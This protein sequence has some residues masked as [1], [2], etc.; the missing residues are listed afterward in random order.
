[1][2]IRSK[3][4]S[5]SRSAKMSAMCRAWFKQVFSFCASEVAFAR[6]SAY[7]AQTVHFAW[8]PTRWKMRIFFPPLELALEG[9]LGGAVLHATCVL[10]HVDLVER[11]HRA[12]RQHLRALC[13]LCQRQTARGHRVMRKDFSRWQECSVASLLL[14][15]ILRR[16]P[17]HKVLHLCEV[18]RPTLAGTRTSIAIPPSTLSQRSP[19]L[20]TK[21]VPHSHIH[22]RNG[23]HPPH[24]TLGL[25]GRR[26]NLTP[27]NSN[28]NTIICFV[29]VVADFAYNI[30]T[31]IE[32]Q[33]GP[34]C[35][36]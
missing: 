12:W 25:L 4:A 21:A 31:P 17:P 16:L 36:C 20:G 6:S 29:R 28:M 5:V 19:P 15:Q 24:K 14:L 30:G 34:I 18:G 23:S 33:I 10:E 3:K 32:N 1:M 11:R 13:Q 7:R 26:P 2:P 9:A 35:P 8:V 22:P 27:P